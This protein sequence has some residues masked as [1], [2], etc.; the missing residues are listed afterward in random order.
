[1]HLSLLEHGNRGGRWTNEIVRGGG[2]LSQGRGEG[3]DDMTRM[4]QR[5]P[6]QDAKDSESGASYSQPQNGGKAWT[7]DVRVLS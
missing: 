3:R 5:V 2:H 1:M 4:G 7:M 6:A